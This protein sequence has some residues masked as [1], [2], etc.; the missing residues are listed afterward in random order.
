M[1]SRA[2]NSDGEDEILAQINIVPFVDIS[3]VLLIIFIVTVN[4]ILTPAIRVR[5]PESSHTDSVADVGS[6]DISISNEG[7]VY[8]G[9]D[10][11][12][13]KELRVRVENMHKIKPQRGVVLGIDKSTYFQRVVDVLDAIN[14]LG[15]TKLDIRTIKH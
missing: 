5:L 14:G 4:Q 15:I 8:L 13:L 3:L 6:I 1:F 2:R 9:K 7:V 11:V 10:I 12:S